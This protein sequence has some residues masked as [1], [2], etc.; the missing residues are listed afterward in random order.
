MDA[1]ILSIALAVAVAVPAYAWLV[2]GRVYATFG[3]VIL[4]IALPGALVMH[5]RLAAWASADV[6][7]WLDVAFIYGVLAGGAHLLHLVRARLRSTVFRA[8]VSIPGMVFIAVGA[9]S[10]LWLLALVPLRAAL[11]LAGWTGALANLRWLDLVP[12]AVGIASV[13]TSLRTVEEV[14]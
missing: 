3:L 6:R 4:A 11:W 1:P 8:F 13:V 10:G 7:P 9:L 14:V 2:R 12:V 5:H